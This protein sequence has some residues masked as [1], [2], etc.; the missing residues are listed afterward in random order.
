[1]TAQQSAQAEPSAAPGSVA[2][3]RVMGIAR[4]AGIKAAVTTEPRTQAELVAA[5]QTQQEPAHGRHR[6]AIERQ[7]RSRLARK[8]PELAA[9]AAARAETVTSTGGSE[10]WFK[11]KDSRV[12]R[13]MR[14]RATAVPKVRVAML[15]PNRG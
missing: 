12:R 11:R 15:N 4:A 6:S 3:D 5:D 13:L 7:W 8:S 2:F 10:C 9:R 1:M 14:L